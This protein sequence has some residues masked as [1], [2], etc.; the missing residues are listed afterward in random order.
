MF[1]STV[2]NRLSSPK[3]VSSSSLSSEVSASIK[4]DSLACSSVASS[5]ACSALRS[6]VSVLSSTFTISQPLSGSAFFAAST[7]EA[8]LPSIKTS[9]FWLISLTV[10]SMSVT[11]TLISDSTS[12]RLNALMINLIN[13][14]KT[15]NAKSDRSAIS[16]WY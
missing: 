15:I 2:S 14:I 10:L 6:V 13:P 16:I 3:P 7:L 5:G 9:C 4:A 8:R 12:F 11:V 1:S